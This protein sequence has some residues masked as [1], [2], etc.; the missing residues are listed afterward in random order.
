MADKTAVNYLRQ[1]SIIGGPDTGKV[2][3]SHP[4]SHDRRATHGTLVT[5]SGGT[6]KELM[7]G[8]GHPTIQAAKL[9]RHATDDRDQELAEETG[10]RV[11]EELKAEEER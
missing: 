5:N 6:I 9:Y 2:G 3:R 4:H 10:K 1:M 8:L 7:R 11:A